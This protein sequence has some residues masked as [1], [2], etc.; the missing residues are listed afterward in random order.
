V[1]EYGRE[2]W[3]ARGGRL[4]FA[5]LLQIAETQIAR[6]QVAAR[7]ANRFLFCDTSPLT[8][9][10]YSRHLFGRVD[11]LLAALAERDYAAHVLCAPDFPFR[12]DGTRQDAAFRTAQHDWYRR[13]LAGRG[14][15][16][17]EAQGGVA[18]RV[19]LVARA[20]GKGGRPRAGPP[21]AGRG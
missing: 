14:I 8:T 17:I 11:P 4:A 7:A 9:L 3:E 13:E 10:F 16:W 6:E 2:L 5:D 21:G 18:E 20:I 1:A 12:Q 19:S 15:G